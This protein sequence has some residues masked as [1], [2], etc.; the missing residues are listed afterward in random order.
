MVRS[1]MRSLSAM[2]QPVL[3]GFVILFLFSGMA[4]RPMKEVEKK[5]TERSG[6]TV[7][8]LKRDPAKESSISPQDLSADQLSLDTA[9]KI[10]LTNNSEIQAVFQDIGIARADVWQATLFRN[11]TF[12]GFV[13]FPNH[14]TVGEGEETR[15]A[16]N[17]VE[18]SVSQDFIDV[19]LMP[20]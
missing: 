9:L 14:D 1:R 20:F 6:I 8:N 16:Q 10:A 15:S 12:D 2:A 19:L 5:V 7:Q 17:N 18:L 11:P 13:R 3:I 4:K